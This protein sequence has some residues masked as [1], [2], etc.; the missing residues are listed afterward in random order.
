MT[1]S[2][3][4]EIAAIKKLRA[5]YFYY[6]GDNLDKRILGLRI[7]YDDNKVL[8]YDY[9]YRYF[10][11]YVSKV[12][13]VYNKEKDKN[14]IILYSDLTEEIIKSYNTEEHSLSTASGD[15]YEGKINL[16]SV[17]NY[18][19][20]DVEDYLRNVILSI[21][22]VITSS[23][24][25]SI[26]SVKGYK[27]NFVAELDS[28]K[29]NILVPFQCVRKSNA[30]YVFK[31]YFSD[32]S[33]LRGIEGNIDISSDG[34][35]V[36][37]DNH[38]KS[39]TG[40]Y[41]YGLS[42]NAR[43]E[44][45]RD[46]FDR[47]LYYN[48]SYSEVVDNAVIKNYSAIVGINPS[49]LISTLSNNYVVCDEE[50]KKS[51]SNVFYKKKTGYITVK[52]GYASI[53]YFYEDG[54]I[55]YDGSLNVHFMNEHMEIKLVPVDVDGEHYILKEVSILPT[56]KMSGEYECDVNKQLYVLMRVDQNSDLRLLFTVL[57]EEEILAS[58]INNLTDTARYVRERKK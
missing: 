19:I 33:L 26:R 11:S 43:V 50:F 34:I 1:N 37:W 3:E 6:V 58:D 24:E 51:D 2:S 57:G 13:E 32:N 16:S 5:I 31:M 54:V 27:N 29:G 46:G 53:N 22:E 14:N 49:K 7:V 25:N 9:T 40:E 56:N 18:S 4:I 55:K 52:R 10:N 8:D 47:I 38:D 39:V 21:M 42:D 45:I 17:P 30:S 44:T 35:K 36:T 20:K 23:E 12:L 15:F 28:V 41:Y 48:D